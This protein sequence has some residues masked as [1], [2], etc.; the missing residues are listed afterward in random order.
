MMSAQAKGI[1]LVTVQTALK[2]SHS[3]LWRGPQCRLP[4]LAARKLGSRRIL[5]HRCNTIQSVESVR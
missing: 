2:A 4:S 5:E 1:G 3:V